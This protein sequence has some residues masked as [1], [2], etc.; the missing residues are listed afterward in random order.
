MDVA[1]DV[2]LLSPVGCESCNYPYVF[3]IGA[4]PLGGQYTFLQLCPAYW[5]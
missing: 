3:Q 5:S 1:G 4:Q 2:I